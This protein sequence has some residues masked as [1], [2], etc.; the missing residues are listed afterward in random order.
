MFAR[1]I[2]PPEII[3]STKE[4]IDHLYSNAPHWAK[5]KAQKYGFVAE[6]LFLNQ[7]KRIEEGEIN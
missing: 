3:L 4:I 7:L 1:I 5:S 6:W 2:D